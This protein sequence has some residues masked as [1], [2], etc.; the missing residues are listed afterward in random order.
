MLKGRN[1]IFTSVLRLW[2]I[3]LD[4]LRD[5]KVETPPRFRS[6]HAIKSTSRWPDFECQ[7]KRWRKGVHN[8]SIT[9]SHPNPRPGPHEDLRAIMD[10]TNNINIIDYATAAKV[11]LFWSG[12]AGRCRCIVVCCWTVGFCNSLWVLCLSSLQPMLFFHT[13]LC[14]DIPLI[15]FGLFVNHYRIDIM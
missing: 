12:A 14:K 1:F 9:S 11:S 7:H 15:L 3:L 8:S 4:K 6:H 13:Y 10:T 2:Q 5:V